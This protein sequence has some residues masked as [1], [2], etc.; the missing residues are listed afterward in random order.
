MPPKFLPPEL[1]D[2]VID[3]LADDVLSLRV[4]SLV[5]SSWLARARHHLFHRVCINPSS[6]GYAFKQLL[7]G[8][9]GLG[10]HV[11]ELEIAGTAFAEASPVEVSEFRWPTLHQYNPDRGA[12]HTPTPD[13]WLERV[14]PRPVEALRQV[15][16]LKLTNLS[17]SK[18]IADVLER[19]F[20]A[21][22][23][24]LILDVCRA[25]TF[26]DFCELSR[27]LRGAECL[28]L[29]D[30]HWL[31]AVAPAPEDHV[32]PLPSLKTLILTGK[33]DSPTVVNSIIA[34]HRYTRLSALCCD[35]VGYPSAAAIRKLLVAVG[36]DLRHLA[37]GFSLA[38]DATGTSSSP[39]LLM[40]LTRI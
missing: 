3:M 12:R 20:A 40:S 2:L 4:C 17:I 21:A 7:E 13:C 16:C 31:R 6:R 22:V 28:H 35:I 23:T 27:A 32:M 9:P 38:R 29:L 24:T 15:T 1:R 34:D 30:F 5:H 33:T 25:A 39:A 37:I 14:L 18:E 8:N 26:R 36:P 11:R 10:R 19:Y